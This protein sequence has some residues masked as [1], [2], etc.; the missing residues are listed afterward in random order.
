MIYWYIIVYVFK[1]VESEFDKEFVLE[2]ELDD[3]EATYEIHTWI[4]MNDVL[5]KKL[6]FSS[7]VNRA[8]LWFGQLCAKI[9]ENVFLRTSKENV[10]LKKHHATDARRQHWL[11][12]I[13]NVR[14]FL[15]RKKRLSLKIKIKKSNRCSKKLIAGGKTTYF[16]E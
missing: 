10:L 15:K 6:L 5:F 4:V 11:V 3:G 1:V 13:Q 2:W 7:P 9:L 12:L 16:Q 8:Q 14:F